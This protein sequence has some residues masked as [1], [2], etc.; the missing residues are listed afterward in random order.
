V[1]LYLTYHAPFDAETI[2]RRA[3]GAIAKPLVH[4]V[5]DAAAIRRARRAGMGVALLGETWRN[6]LPPGH[7]KRGPAF[8]QLPY[9]LDGRLDIEARLSERFVA[10][11]AAGH[12]D[13]QIA[14]GATLLRTT[15]HVLPREGGR[16]RRNELAFARATIAEYDDRRGRHSAAT[17]DPLRPLFATIVVR[18]QHLLGGA[19]AAL[20]DAYVPLDV[21]GYWIVIANHNQ[22]LREFKAVAALCDRLERRTGRPTVLA[23]VGTAHLA[24]LGRDVVSATCIGHHGASLRFP[25]IDWSSTTAGDERR[26]FGIPVHHR[27]ILGAVPLGERYDEARGILFDRWPCRCGHHGPRVPPDGN[28]Q[29]IAHNAWTLM[30]DAASLCARAAEDRAAYLDMRM[31]RAGLWRSELRLGRLRAGWR[32]PAEFVPDADE[33]SEAD[34]LPG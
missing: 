23:G 10:A 18:A 16:G 5:A 3:I 29:K 1:I 21:D 8:E 31:D 27:T 22:S 2:D 24:F 34:E 20:A 30:S 17:G 9:A 14:G 6:Q 11:Y 15:G 4:A 33:S 19:H 25:P 26:E 32:G 7:Q 13:A 12:L 28:A